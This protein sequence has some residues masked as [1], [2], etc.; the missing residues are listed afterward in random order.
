MNTN[1]SKRVVSSGNRT[2][3]GS[4]SP[5]TALSPS[6]GLTRKRVKRIRRKPKRKSKQ[7]KIIIPIG[8]C[9]L[10][11]LIFFGVVRPVFFGGDDD[12][13]GGANNNIN[14]RNSHHRHGQQSHEEDDREIHKRKQDF[15]Q[16]KRN[17]M[18]KF[19]D[20][21]AENETP[22]D[23]GFLQR[24]R[25]GHGKYKHSDWMRT[26]GDHSSHYAQLRQE[27]DL[28]LPENDIPRMQ[29]AVSSLK[30]NTY[31]TIMEDEMPY[32]IHD[33]PEY[34]PPNYPYAWNVKD[35]IENWPPDDTFT[36]RH[37]IYQGL[38]VFDFQTEEDKALNYR[39]AEVPFIVQNDPA[40]MRTVERWNQPGYI[41]SLLGERTRYRTEF[42]HNNHFMYWNK[43]N[44]RARANGKVP[45][46]W[47][48]PTKMSRMTYP[49]WLEHANVTDEELLRPNKDHWYFRLIGCGEMGSCDKDSSEYLFDE[50]S[51]FQPKANNEL[52]MPEPKKQ[53]GIHC[54]FGMKGV[55][56]ENHFDGSRNMIA[57]L[58]G[59][60]RYIL[61]HPDQCENLALYPRGHPSARHS[62]VDWSD[63]N[64]E[65]FPQF[66]DAEVNEV[67]LQAGDVLYLPTNW[68]HYI[69]SLDLN[70]QC[71][72]R[73]GIT[74]DYMD[75][76]D[77]CGF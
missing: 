55:I 35:V 8:L 6:T 71:N 28:K 2:N 74:N 12:D 20:L 65:K 13:N 30:Y 22:S 37:N 52:Y 15:Y 42:S 1:V 16:N 59:E 48:P 64:W 75:A 34:P 63:P 29:K 25:D 10:S 44:K 38:C 39:E 50:L 57:L 19:N 68:F 11:V 3:I 31:H 58:G 14:S 62:A 66:A 51:F 46:D 72:T 70:L 5:S 77:R 40:V 53:K 18:N 9:L 45:E 21:D 17:R 36:V 4:S 67:V 69:I 32:K 54:R 23:E 47:R 76:I 7:A 49:D 56:A 33:C 26:V 61:S 27:Y 24:L 41:R 73:S 60:R 43:P